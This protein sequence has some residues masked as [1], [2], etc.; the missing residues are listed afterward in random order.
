MLELKARPRKPGK[1]NALRRKGQVPAV[2][3]G[4]TIDSKAITV[5]ARPLR[6]L[7][8]HITRSS[9][10]ELSF[11]DGEKDEKLDVFVKDI[12]YNPMTDSPIH[13]DF[14][15]PDIGH[16]LRLDVPL[17]LVGQPPGVKAGGILNILFRNI[18]VHGLPKDIPPIIT[19]DVS[20]LDMGESIHVRDVDFGAVEPL[21]QQERT[22]VTIMSPRAEEEELLPELEEE[23]LLE[24]VAGEAVEEE[25]GEEPEESAEETD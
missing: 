13:V 15:H 25:E 1:A 24:T 3:Y 8:S 19:L 21:L 5:G 23:A 7:F 6:D 4:P 17:K 14:Y 18:P 10:I 16:P 22:L 9:R 11:A 20:E 12:Q 2:V